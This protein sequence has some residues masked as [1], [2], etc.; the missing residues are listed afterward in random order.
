MEIGLAKKFVKLGRVR[1]GLLLYI[2]TAQQVFVWHF[3]NFV[4]R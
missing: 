3:P 2:V 1:L 4:Q